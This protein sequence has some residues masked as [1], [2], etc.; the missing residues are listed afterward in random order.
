MRIFINDFLPA[1]S[2]LVLISFIIE[3][4]VMLNSALYCQELSEKNFA[5]YNPE[6]FVLL[7]EKELSSLKKRYLKGGLKNPGEFHVQEAEKFLMQ[8]PS[9]LEEIRYEG[10]VSN[11]PDRISSVQ[12]LKDMDYLNS[13]TW[14]YILTENLKYAAKAKEILISWSYSY[15][16]T[17][18]DVNENKLLTMFMSYFYL[19]KEFDL[20]PVWD[21][22][23]SIANKQIHL[24]EVNKKS[25]NRAAKRIKLVLLSGILLE[26]KDF[27]SWALEKYD[28]IHTSSLYYDG[29]SWDFLRRDA[30]SYHVDGIQSLLEV[31]VLA[32][33][34]NYDLFTKENE[35]GGSLKK[36]IDFVI[37]Y[38]LGEKTHREWINTTVELDKKRWSAGDT[39]YMP[40]KIWDPIESIDMFLLASIFDSKYLSIAESILNMENRK[41]F[42]YLQIQAKMINNSF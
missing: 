13:L 11:H 17:G 26:R 34:L 25:G 15:Q 24:A 21:L 31:C 7:N 39:Y 40:G 29:T 9:P 32:R 37:P 18:N 36:S 41:S 5:E 19:K 23:E 12:H 33:E 28:S 8:K 3:I 10:L 30:L 4:S 38:V 35:G 42:L 27:I 6:P 1:F 16:P 22:I 14:A 2:H 20:K